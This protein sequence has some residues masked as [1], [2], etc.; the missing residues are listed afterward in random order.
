VRSASLTSQP[1]AT[2][3]CGEPITVGAPDLLRQV[4]LDADLA[5]SRPQPG[6]YGLSDEPFA[7]YINR[8][9][10]LGHREV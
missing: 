9:P 5:Q 1:N 8:T 10:K 6:Q 7:R 2:G 3:T 4:S